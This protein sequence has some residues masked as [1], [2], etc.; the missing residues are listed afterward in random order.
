MTRRITVVH[1]FENGGVI[2]E[3]TLAVGTRDSGHCDRVSRVERAPSSSEIPLATRLFPI[4]MSQPANTERLS[5]YTD[6]MN[7]LLPVIFYKYHPLIFSNIYF[8]R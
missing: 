2:L 7:E 4:I 5:F 3:D 6:L 1:V 8:C